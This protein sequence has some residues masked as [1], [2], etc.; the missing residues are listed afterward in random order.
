MVGIRVLRS[1][2]TFADR[3]TH[4]PSTN[5]YV[6]AFRSMWRQTHANPACPATRVDGRI[7]LVTGGSVGIG[8]ETSRGLASRGAEV[9]SVARDR[10][11]GERMAASLTTE[12]DRPA[13]FLAHDLADLR[14]VAPTLHRL[15]ALLRGRPLDVLVANAGLWPTGAGRSPQG[16]EIAF[17]TNVLG[18]AALI[19]GAR[20]RGLLARDC[21]V[22]I[23]TGDLYVA[24]R[25]CSPDFDARGAFGGFRAYARSKLGNLWYARE[26]ARR[27]PSLSVL[28]VH[29]GIVATGLGGSRGGL[30]GAVRRS[31][32][33]DPEQGAQ[34][35]LYCATQPDLVSGGYYHNVLGRMELRGDDPAMDDARASA[36]W[37]VL[38]RLRTPERA[39]TLEPS[40]SL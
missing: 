17:A 25:R 13:H 6:R 39:P 21:R 35:T 33:L 29:P 8:F 37:D 18:H 2:T 34:T 16:H 32:L 1:T 14:T 27:V 12:C 40:R 4:R 20:E 38:E 11:A 36:L 30:F 15:E 26:L 9:I 5:A 23:V 3:V 10:V 31:I 24:E 19:D 28:A 7:A 22:V